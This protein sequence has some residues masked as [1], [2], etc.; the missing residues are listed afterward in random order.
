VDQI[1]C[2]LDRYAVSALIAVLSTVFRKE[3]G[4]RR[5]LCGFCSP[6]SLMDPICAGERKIAQTPGEVLYAS[7]TAGVIRRSA[8]PQMQ[9][10]SMFFLKLF[11]DCCC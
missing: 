3:D 11:G 8:E 10:T 2:T 1:P 5:I 4:G 6:G 7:G 9:R